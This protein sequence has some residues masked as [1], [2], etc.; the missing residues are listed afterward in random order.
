MR[1]SH[2]CLTSS[3]LYIRYVNKLCELHLECDN[4][5]EAAYTLKLHSQLLDFSDQALPPLLRSHRYPACNTHRELK[6]ALYNDMIDYF[7]KG[8]MWE[9]AL[10]V[11]KELVAQYEEETYDYLQLS[12]L[13][14]RMAKFYD[15]IV[16]KFRS[17]PE[18]FRVAYYGRGHP[19]FLQNKVYVYRGKGY[20]R[21]SEFSQ[22]T[23]KQLPNVEKMN[24]WSPPTE[25]IMESNSQYVLINK[26]D[27][28]MD[29]KRHRLSGKPVTAEAVLKYHR[30]NDVQ[31]FVFSRPAPKRENSSISQGSLDK[32]NSDGS[33]RDSKASG[34]SNNEF[35][36]LWLERTVLSTSH[37]LP[38]ILRWFPVVSSDTYFVSPLRNAIETMEASNT[39]LRDLIIAHKSDPSLPLKQFTMKLQGML[40]P[41]VMGGIDNYEKAFLNP[42]YKEAHLQESADLLK[43]ESVIAEQIPL[44]GVGVQLHKTMASS[45]LMP[46]QLRLEQCFAAMR[47]QVEAKYGKRVSQ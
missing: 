7:D 16:K 35:G 45:D 11:C 31:R 9:C 33:S 32:E 20:E 41:A 5:I 27:P 47:M 26:V 24:R 36:S 43:L 2:F 22:R 3:N 6:E 4:Y 25:E 28:V 15:L 37:P 21:L 14:T 39:A 12:V 46:L 34:N 29:E 44:L 38:G 17:A 10:G 1:V 19:P 13:L 30:V 18:Y 23:L 40:D 42:G 8:E